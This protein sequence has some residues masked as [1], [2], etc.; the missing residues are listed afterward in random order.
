[1]KL[2]NLKKKI[3]NIIINLYPLNK[4]YFLYKIKKLS[5]KKY[6]YAENAEDVIINTL[7]NHRTDG[8]YIDVGCYHPVRGSLTYKLYNKG[9]RGVNIDIS[10]SSIN[11]FN[12]ARPKDKNL[13]V[14]ITNNNGEGFYYQLSNINQGNS[15]KKYDNAEKIKIKLSTIDQIITD[16]KIEKID[17]INI[18]A[19]Y[20][21]FEALQGLSL[22]KVRPS[23]ITIEDANNFDISNIINTNINKY[24][25]ERNYFFFSRTICTSFYIDNKFKDKL[26]NILNT[27]NKISL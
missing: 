3:K 15:L 14:G 26:D 7:F 27:R 18:D 2:K 5:K 11:L 13:N 16:L 24:L 4:I 12:I 10:S 8:Y 9:W 19:E 25:V 22:S 1:M 21:D 6:Y 23:L 17:Y 20:R